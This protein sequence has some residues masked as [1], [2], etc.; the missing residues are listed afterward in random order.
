LILSANFKSLF[1]SRNVISGS[2]GLRLELYQEI[3]DETGN[4]EKLLEHTVV[5]D[6]SDMMGNPYLF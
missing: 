4:I 1:E 3:T 2:Y 6:S 5:L